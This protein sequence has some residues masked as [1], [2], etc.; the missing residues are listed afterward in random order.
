MGVNINEAFADLFIIVN[1]KPTQLNVIGAIKVEDRELVVL[2]D[3]EGLVGQ[4][5]YMVYEI[6]RNEENIT[7]TEIRD[8]EF[9]NHV[10]DMW[11]TYLDELEDTEIDS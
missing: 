9:Y 4:D 6:I 2:S 8:M 5:E 11:E 1:G 3:M 10:C 7:L